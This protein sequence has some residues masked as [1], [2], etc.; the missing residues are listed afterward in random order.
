[1][2]EPAFLARLRANV[3]GTAGQP[4]R[5]IAPRNRKVAVEDG[6]DAPQYVLDDGS[7]IGKEEFARLERGD[8]SAL[9]EKEEM[10]RDGDGGGDMDGEATS[11]MK[12]GGEEMPAVSSVTDVGGKRKRKAAKIV[13]GDGE[14]DGSVKDKPREG[15]KTK[16]TG[17]RKQRVKLSFEDE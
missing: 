3:A 15:G 1:M 16:A 6:D 5:Y 2:K 7:V 17:K 13:G 11:G 14:E 4:E 8:E 9:K 10:D 12:K